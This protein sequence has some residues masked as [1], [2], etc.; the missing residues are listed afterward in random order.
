M[1]LFERDRR[2]LPD[3]R[4]LHARL[5]VVLTRTDHG[6]EA[7]LG[8]VSFREEG[9]PTGWLEVDLLEA[10]AAGREPVEQYV[11]RRY[12]GRRPEFSMNLLPAEGHGGGTRS[13]GSG[14]GDHGSARDPIRY[15]QVVGVW[16]EV[17]Y[18]SR[19]TSL[20]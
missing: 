16:T 13:S 5:C 15:E 1:L 6:H 8:L 12:P 10:D 4:D 17:L 2:R 3:A 20:D 9:G 14:E 19:A 18:R 7:R 11:I